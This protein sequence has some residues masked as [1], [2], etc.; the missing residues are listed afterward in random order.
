MCRYR[1]LRLT[2]TMKLVLIVYL[3]GFFCYAQAECNSETATNVPYD[4]GKNAE[5]HFYETDQGECKYTCMKDGK[6]NKC[7]QVH[8][9]KFL[10]KYIRSPC[11]QLAFNCEGIGEEFASE[12]EDTCSFGCRVDDMILSCAQAHPLTS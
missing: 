9:V 2:I 3:T 12:S 4:C 7:E 8:R 6:H 5:P 10:E 1:L 11:R